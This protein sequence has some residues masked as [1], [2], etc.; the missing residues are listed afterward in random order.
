[1][2]KLHILT[3]VI[4]GLLTIS[5]VERSFLLQGNMHSPAGIKGFHF[6]PVIRAANISTAG[7]IEGIVD[8]G[9]TVQAD[10]S[11]WISTDTVVTSAF[12]DTVGYYAMPGIPAGFYSVSA[13]K[14]G[15]DT[16]TVE[17]V[18]IM[19]GNRTVQ[20]FTLT[21]VEESPEE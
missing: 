19:K 18:E 20:N 6:K 7:S 8:D 9:D 1:M 4:L 11:V 14:D 16:V 17:G 12:T 10:V 15:Y 13:A 5:R 3:A 2:I 21:A